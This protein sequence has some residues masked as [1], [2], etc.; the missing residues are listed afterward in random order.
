MVDHDVVRLDVAVHDASGMTKVEGLE[1]LENVV[2]HVV[3]GKLWVQDFK[4]SAVRATS[5]ISTPRDTDTRAD[6]ILVHI[7]K[8]DGR[9]FRLRVAHDVEQSDNVGPSRQI[10]Q[11]LDLSLYLLLLDGFED[12]DDALFFV[13]NV[14]A[15]KDFRVLPSPY[16]AND[17]VVVLLPVRKSL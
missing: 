15:L 1:Q 14:D 8:D 3:V 6:H 11:D 7:L 17:L 9:C 16:F 5:Y 2:P 10:L 13:L 12:L 4:V